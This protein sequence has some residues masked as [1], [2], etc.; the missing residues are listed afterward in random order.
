MVARLAEAPPEAD[1]PF[2]VTS[3]VGRRRDRSE[4]KRLLSQSRQVTLTG[5]GGVGKTRLAA[6]VAAEV[7]RAFPD[8]VRYVSLAELG[9]PALLEDV[10]ATQLGL[11]DHS[12]QTRRRDLVDYLR[13]RA[14]LIVLDN[15]EHL[16]EACADLTS[17]LLR[18][19]PRLRILATSRQPLGIAGEAVFVVP[20]LAV[21]ELPRSGKV[22]D[23]SDSVMLFV[24]RARL[25]QPD[26][27]ITEGNRAA[28]L[29]ICQQLEGIPLALELA[30]VR[31]RALSPS[32]ILVMLT[33]HW[34]L[35]TL[36]N[37]SAPERHRTMEG[38]L[39]WS[40]RLCSPE[41]QDLW[42]RT[43]AFA[44]GF[45]LDAVASLFPAD[46]RPEPERLLDL[47]TSLVE[48]SILIT[49]ER[50]GRVRHR[51]LDTVRMHGLRRLDES[52][53]LLN[54][55]RLHRAWCTEL[56]AQANAE[57]L[58]PRQADWA[59]RLR[60]EQANLQAALEFCSEEPDEAEAGL[61]IAINLHDYAV[62]QG[63]FRPALHWFDR[64]LAHPGGTMLT[65]VFALRTAA[66]LATLQGDLAAAETLIAQGRA[67]ATQL[68]DLA[69]ACI[70]QVSGLY[71][72]F[73]GQPVQAITEL[74]RALSVFRHIGPPI[75]KLQTI[76]MLIVAHGLAGH[77]DRGLDYYRESR[78][79]TE[80]AGELWYRSMSIWSAGLIRLA[81]GDSREASRL[82][83][84]S[85]RLSD[86]FDNRV[87][88]ALCLDALAWAAAGSNA[89]QAAVLLGAADA[90]W[91]AMGTSVTAL[92][93][94]AA[95]R[96]S[97]E[98]QVREALGDAGFTSAYEQGLA[99]ERSAAIDFALGKKPSAGT[100]RPRPAGQ[101]PTV[102]TKRERQVAE[103][104]GRGLTNREVASELVI[105]TRTAEAARFR[106]S[107]SR[108]QG[109]QPSANPPCG[110]RGPGVDVAFARA[111]AGAVTRRRS[112]SGGGKSRAF[113][114]PAVPAQHQGA[115]MPVSHRHT[116]PSPFPAEAFAARAPA[117][118][119]ARRWR[120]TAPRR[121][122]PAGQ[123]RRPAP[124]GRARCGRPAS[125]TPLRSVATGPSRAAG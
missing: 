125:A 14:I 114:R 88:I 20:P 115:G 92:P 106:V 109:S 12:R 60:R 33:A 30:A 112:P 48:K 16:L 64:L 54:L 22:V 28:V 63:L 72:L 90:R 113:W 93:G 110:V 95:Q 41:E 56:S 122:R 40:Y 53:E 62:V 6:R 94:L 11:R 1:L 120:R 46:E 49:E 23:A 124:A 70:D 35:L 18:V 91:Q 66:R 85:L 101:T 83:Q 86:E 100:A 37:R 42:A 76:N 67:A 68:G 17:A 119:R 80:P 79:I 19:C 118:G 25:V 51:M 27:A 84:D 65:R 117:P 105:S 13:P 123:L 89:R 74:E 32:E 44:G 71:E 7:R 34:R 31:L 2:D 45:E 82:E 4:V 98:L 73:S 99:L 108:I 39:D 57:W 104:I 38:C 50:D 97:Y 55:R 43:A 26:F 21:P 87:G 103:L 5:F 96:G 15:C 121:S 3:F 116:R 58:S 47:V 10:V 75:L 111:D 36:G 52:G 24:D 9:E 61:Q 107:R 78:D 59:A 77:H 69:V 81:Q 8:G 29:G 102:L